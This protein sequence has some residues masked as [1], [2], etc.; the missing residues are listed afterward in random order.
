MFAIC[1]SKNKTTC[2]SYFR[3]RGKDVGKTTSLHFLVVH[4]L[5]KPLFEVPLRWAKFAYTCKTHP[6]HITG[7]RHRRQVV[8][9]CL[10]IFKQ[11]L[12]IRVVTPCRSLP[13]WS[14]PDC[15]PLLRALQSGPEAP[16]S[17]L[18]N[19]ARALAPASGSK[20]QT[21]RIVLPALMSRSSWF[22]CPSCWEVAMFPPH[23]RFTLT[24][25]WIV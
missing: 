25:Q 7:T 9:K 10:H 1:S 22:A 8:S 17:R 11:G 20:S 16:R 15:P 21:S 6:V 19:A 24:S 13:R 3:Q 2:P 14:L 12:V 23:C 5:S 18:T 4:S